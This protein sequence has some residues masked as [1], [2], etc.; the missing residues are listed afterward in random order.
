MDGGAIAVEIAND[1]VTQTA[2]SRSRAV[3]PDGHGLAGMRERVTALGGSL[4]ASPDGGGFKV[5]GIVPV[6]GKRP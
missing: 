5:T 4:R 3:S 2:I 6:G 1:G